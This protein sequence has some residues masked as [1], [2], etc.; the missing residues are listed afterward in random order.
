MQSVKLIKLV[1]KM[2]LIN[3]TPEVAIDDIV[4][5]EA[6]INRPALQLAGFYDYFSSQRLQVIGNV[7]NAYLEQQGIEKTI[8]ILENLMKVIRIEI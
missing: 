7:E 8:E 5:T 3:C 4:L 2:G 6:D 1:E